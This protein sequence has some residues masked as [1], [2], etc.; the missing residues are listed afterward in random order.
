[1]Y[2]IFAGGITNNMVFLARRRVSDLSLCS[3]LLA[4]TFDF[5]AKLA[6]QFPVFPNKI[7]FAIIDFFFLICLVVGIYIIACIWNLC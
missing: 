3:W 2:K 5:G 7:I 1:M 6:L 4:F